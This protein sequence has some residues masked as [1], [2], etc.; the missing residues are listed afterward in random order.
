MCFLGQEDFFCFFRE[1][2]K[3]M[4]LAASAN[5]VAPLMMPTS[6]YDVFWRRRYV[7]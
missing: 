5:Y 2:Q 3:E 4:M 6:P 1:K 7:V